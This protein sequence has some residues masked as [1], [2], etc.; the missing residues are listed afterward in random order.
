MM[1][2]DS[3]PKDR[4]GGSGGNTVLEKGRYPA[5]VKSASIKNGP[6]GDYFQAVLQVTAPDGSTMLVFD[7]FFNSDKPLPQYKL[8]QFLRSIN[9]ILSGNFEMK[10]L[11]KI[12][13]NKRLEVVLKVEPATDKYAAKN[14]AD[15][16]DDMIYYPVA[17]SVAASR[18]D[19]AIANGDDECPFTMG[20]DEY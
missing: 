6:S 17:G 7:N 12:V 20:A 9:C 11:V 1:N 2:F 4:P 15:A 3:L 8:G 18:S 19:A 14:V 10:D 16:F 5:V 13:V